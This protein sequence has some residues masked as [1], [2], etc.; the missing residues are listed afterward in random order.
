MFAQKR[1]GKKAVTEQVLFDEL[2]WGMNS[3]G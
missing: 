2:P 3:A 1:P